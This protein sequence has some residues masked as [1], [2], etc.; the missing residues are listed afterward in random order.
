MQRS[1]ACLDTIASDKQRLVSALARLYLLVGKLLLSPANLA[2]GIHT[3]DDVERLFSDPDLKPV[4]YF[5]QWR[6]NALRLYVEDRVSAAER[7][8]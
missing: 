7:V 1:V 5:D 6:L 2:E 3:M 4:T 8:A